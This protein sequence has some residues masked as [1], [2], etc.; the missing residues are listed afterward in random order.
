MVEQDWWDTVYIRS[1]H[2]AQYRNGQWAKLRRIVIRY[3]R[4]CF[5]VQFIDDKFDYWVTYDNPDQYEF[6]GVIK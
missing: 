5:E 4:P 1:T 2:P 6:M 3:N